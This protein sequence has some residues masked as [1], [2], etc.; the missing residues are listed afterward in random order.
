MSVYLSRVSQYDVPKIEEAFQSGIDNLSI[1]LAGKKSAVIKV[2]IVQPRAPESGVITHPAVAEAIINTLRAHGVERIT[3]AEGPALGVDARK[4]F[5]ESGY[6]ELAKRLRV[7]LVNLFDE[8]R[9][10]LD[11]G[12]GYKD[13]P[14]VYRDEDLQNYYC[15]Y[16]PIPNIFLESDIYISV[17]KLKTHNRTTVSLSL[18]HQWGLLPFKERQTYHRVGLHEPI[19]HLARAVKPHIVVIDG[20]TG[21]EGNGPVLGK[22]RRSEVIAIGTDMLETDIV[23][24]ELM[25]QEPRN[26]THFNYAVEKGV[27]TWDTNVI[28]TPVAELAQPFE[29]APQG[30]KK[31]LNFYVWRNHR[32]CHLDDESFKEAFKIVKRTPK[33]WFTFVPKFA[34][35]VLLKRIDVVKGRGAVMPDVNNGGKILL[36]GECVRDL[37][38]NMEETPPNVVFVPGCPPDPE[39]IIKAIIGM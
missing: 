37:I 9:T 10:K 7:K 21:L 15:G 3:I 18:K 26:I 22:P 6:E 19:V 28:G 16:L 13:L 30:L 8:P 2:N 20:I 1:D 34:Y 4:A 23:G 27:G 25:K 12:Y 5:R 17:P 29:P 38:E 31:N 33:Y 35:Y 24:A 14:N 39:G 11:V 36:S 32:A